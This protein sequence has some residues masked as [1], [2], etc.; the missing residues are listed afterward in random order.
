V[1]GVVV[2][3]AARSSQLRSAPTLNVGKEVEMAKQD[4]LHGVTVTTV[5]KLPNS[6]AMILETFIEDGAGE[7]VE[8]V[9]GGTVARTISLNY[10]EQV[11]PLQL[12][13]GVTVKGRSN[14]VPV[15]FAMIV[16]STTRPWT[17]KSPK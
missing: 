11:S 12:N 6:D 1:Y 14:G 7:M 4:N 8:D 13:M 15:Q 2:L 17:F 16:A 10:G 3:S 9:F 5:K